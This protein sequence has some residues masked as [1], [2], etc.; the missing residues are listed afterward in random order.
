MY[1]YNSKLPRYNERSVNY[2]NVVLGEFE[3]LGVAAI[4]V[5]NPLFRMKNMHTKI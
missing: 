2:G 4:K 3:C 1:V 5:I